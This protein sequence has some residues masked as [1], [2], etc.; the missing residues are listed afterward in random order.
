VDP[1]ALAEIDL[2]GGGIATA[3][4]AAAHLAGR[5][6]WQAG[7]GRAH[8]CATRWELSTTSRIQ[9]MQPISFSRPGTL[10]GSL[11]YV[12]GSAAD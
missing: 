8:R 11:E 10:V 1:A 7:D 4:L 12:P 5:G 2:P 3:A 9:V 6:L